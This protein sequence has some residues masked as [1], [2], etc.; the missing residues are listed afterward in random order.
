MTAWTNLKDITLSEI[1]QSQKDEHCV[2]PLTWDINAADL[3]GA[4]EGMGVARAG[5]GK[6]GVVI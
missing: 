5:E 3:V 6:R 2:I 1:S 4:K